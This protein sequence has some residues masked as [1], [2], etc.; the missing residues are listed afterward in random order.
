[1]G[2]PVDVIGGTSQ[3]AF[4]AALYAQGLDKDELQKRVRAYAGA[5][6][7][8]R[9]ILSDITL[10]VLSFFSGKMFDRVRAATFCYYAA[11]AFFC[12][13]SLTVALELLLMCLSFKPCERRI[14]RCICM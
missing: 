3:G 6:T 12:L 2:T 1:V 11:H 10:P 14:R 4:M 5:M 8:A 9:R 13:F 7:S